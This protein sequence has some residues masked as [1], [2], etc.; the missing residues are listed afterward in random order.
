MQYNIETF[1]SK[2]FELCISQSLKTFFLSTRSVDP[3]LL[4]L[5]ELAGENHRIILR[6]KC[7]SH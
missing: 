6:V 2:G 5:R 3:D 1:S 7:S 4:Y